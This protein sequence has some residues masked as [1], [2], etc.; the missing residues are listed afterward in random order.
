MHPNGLGSCA[1]CSDSLLISLSY[2]M[3]VFSMKLFGP[4]FSNPTQLHMCMNL[5]S[6]FK[7][8]KIIFME[9]LFPK[10]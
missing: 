5:S 9:H 8:V 4:F 6:T 7:K 10:V 3:A 2:S 1:S